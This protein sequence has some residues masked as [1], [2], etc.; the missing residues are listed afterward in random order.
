MKIQQINILNDSEIK[1]EMQKAN[2]H[3]PIFI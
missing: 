3:H 1:A 2:W